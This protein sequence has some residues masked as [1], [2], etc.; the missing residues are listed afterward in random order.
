SHSV[1]ATAEEACRLLAI[2]ARCFRELLQR[3]PEIAVRLA[4]ELARRVRDLSDELEAM[5]F[6]SIGE[7]VLRRL[8]ELAR[9][10]RELR[11]THQA[12]AEQVGASRENV[13]RVLG[14]LRE[15]RLIELGRGRIT[16]LDHPRLAAVRPD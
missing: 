16:I 13:S 7:R 4:I 2:P 8:V 3:R 11:L 10:R 9:D 1:Y 5:K 15:R 12:L 14:L 6:A